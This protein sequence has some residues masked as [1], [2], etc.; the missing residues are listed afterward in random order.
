MPYCNAFVDSRS[1]YPVVKM[2]SLCYLH[3]ATQEK[4]SRKNITN[5]YIIVNIIFTITHYEHYYYIDIQLILLL[6]LLYSG[7]FII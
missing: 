1:V 2:V 6:P 3:R 4:E 7:I 5:I